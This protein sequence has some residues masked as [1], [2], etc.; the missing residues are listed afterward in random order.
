MATTALSAAHPPIAERADIHKSCK[1]LESLLNILNEYC[2]AVSVVVSLQKK[3]AK[4]LKETAAL[5]VTG[6][7]AGN[8][9]S[10]SANIFEA[11]SEIDA[12]YTK[13]ADKEYDG[14]S[15]EVKKW[16]KKLVKEEKAHDE[17]LESANAKIKQAGQ[18]YEKK[19][20]KKSFDASEEH[21]RYINLIST[22]GPEISQD[23]YNH[24]MNVTQKH[25]TITF[26]V[27]AC[28]ARIADAEWLK[29][30]EGVRRFAPTIGTLAQWRVMCEGG[31]AQPLPQG[32]PEPDQQQQP[33]SGSA[34]PRETS[35]HQSE[36]QPQLAKHSPKRVTLDIPELREGPS[37]TPPR[38]S[39]IEHDSGQPSPTVQRQPLPSPG[40]SPQPPSPNP[41][42]G[43]TAPPGPKPPPPSAFD[44]LKQPF[45]D[46]VTG[47]VR[48]LSAFPAPPTHFPIPPPRQQSQQSSLSTL[49]TPQPLSESPMSASQVLWAGDDRR[50]GDEPT[51]GLT[52]RNASMQSQPDSPALE[53]R[54]PLPVRAATTQPALQEV[55]EDPAVLSDPGYSPGR[56]GSIPGEWT[57]DEPSNK[58]G[59]NEFTDREFG[60]DR[61][62]GQSAKTR[63][64]DALRTRGAERT[65]TGASSGSVVAAMRNRYSSNSGSTSPPPR[66]LPKIPLSVTDLASKYEGND[67]QISA[68]ARASSPPMARQQSLPLEVRTKQESSHYVPRMSH[69]P[70]QHSIA[71]STPT[72]EEDSRR[73]MGDE[74]AERQ[75]LERQRELAERERAIEAEA[76]ELERERA[77]LANL[78]GSVESA[79][80]S[81]GKMSTVAEE[82]H[83]GEPIRAPIS[84]LRPRRISLRKQLQ[85]PLSQMDLDDEESPSPTRLRSTGNQGRYGDSQHNNTPP[86]QQATHQQSRNGDDHRNVRYNDE[87]QSPTTSSSPHA[88]YCGCE[89]CSIA[90]YRT[91]STSTTDSRPLSSGNLLRP[92]INSDKPKGGWMRRLSMP[93]G[94]SN[95]FSLDSKRNHHQNAGV[96]GSSPNYALGSGVSSKGLLSLDSKKNASSTSLMRSPGAE[97]VQEDGWLAGGGGGR[98][99]YEANRSMTNLALGSRR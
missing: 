98:R 92:P 69:R 6:E 23:K 67:G 83:R 14:I 24:A 7:V 88:P 46:P 93:G 13:V 37:V 80:Q 53:V 82:P 63:S 30:C 89:T 68:R 49:T 27:A 32:L 70:G 42:A 26:N 5:K 58:G 36:P 64:Y 19:S 16:F 79:S 87:R 3:L 4:V 62:T 72:L 90:K 29:A 20:K 2:E 55:K 76:R 60:M 35:D 59:A 45:F 1:S 8:A 95:A 74:D 71:T 54:R 75:L 39:P 10:A 31:W 9:F 41:Q 40:R 77:R 96:S 94:L 61:S 17:R 78:R 22:L 84:P 56:K 91:P 97:R 85:R 33:S 51:S 52:T 50:E 34:T 66:A 86:P 11:L 21:A 44:T 57:E 65:D 28:L 38:Y 18:L 43:T 15:T 99:S 48:T 73:R 12:K 47:S 25:S 81:G